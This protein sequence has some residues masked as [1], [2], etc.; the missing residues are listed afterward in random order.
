MLKLCYKNY[1]C[2]SIIAIYKIQIFNKIKNL[3]DFYDKKRRTLRDY[4]NKLRNK[5][6]INKQL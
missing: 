4:Y 3:I 5:I 6:L 2:L 1:I